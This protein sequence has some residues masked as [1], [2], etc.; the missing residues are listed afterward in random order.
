[1]TSSTRNLIQ[2]LGFGMM[3]LMAVATVVPI[4]GTV[5]YIFAQG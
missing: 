4:I 1:M 2:R 5:V 3:T